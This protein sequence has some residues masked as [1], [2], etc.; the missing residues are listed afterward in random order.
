MAGNH[1]ASAAAAVGAA[2]AAAGAD[3][4]GEEA[5]EQGSKLAGIRVEIKELKGD[6]AAYEALDPGRRERYAQRRY[7]CANGGTRKPCRRSWT[8]RPSD[9]RRSEPFL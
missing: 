6:L 7:R 1:A 4:A 3:P 2:Q 8:W 9:S 5:G